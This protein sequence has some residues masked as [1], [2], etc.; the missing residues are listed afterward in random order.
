MLLLALAC[1]CLRLR[2][3]GGGDVISKMSNAPFWI[4]VVC[5]CYDASSITCVG[6]YNEFVSLHIYM[7]QYNSRRIDSRFAK[8]AFLYHSKQRAKSQK[9]RKYGLMGVLL[10]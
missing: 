7:D 10:L 6:G 8:L 9:S 1:A 4:L 2:W 3:A 5:R